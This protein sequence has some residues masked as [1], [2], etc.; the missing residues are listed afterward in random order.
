MNRLHWELEVIERASQ[1]D[2]LSAILPPGRAEQLAEVLTD[3]DVRTL[4]HL[5]EKG[6]GENSLRALTSDFGYIEAWARAATGSPLPWPAP[7][8]LVLKFV[9]HHLWD[10][11][12]RENDPS[13][14]MPEEVRE[15]L[16]DQ[17][18]LRSDGPHAVSTVR[19]RLSSWA[20]LSSWRGLAGEFGAPQLRKALRLASRAQDRRRRSKSARALS[21]D[22]L[23]E[24]L[25]ALDLVCAGRSATG[26][27][28][29]R[30][31]R[32][33]ALRDRAMLSVAF[34]AGGRRRSEIASMSMGQIEMFDRNGSSA[35]LKCRLHLSRTKTTDASDGLSV[36]IVGRSVRDLQAWLDAAGITTGPIFRRVDRWGRIGTR[37]ITAQSVNIAVKR[38]A[39]AVNLDPDDF[40]AH[41]LRSGYMT[42]ALH[43]GLSL[44]EAM[45]Q[46][47]HRSVQQAASYFRA[48]ERS[49]HRAA[50]LLR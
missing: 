49:T 34:S 38:R 2:A 17:G 42:E 35:E 25:D 1:L 44:P 7:L 37:A 43:Q 16:I 24:L 30:A 31:E 9:A 26:L 15:S 22:I 12:E 29:G 10:P 6:M 18:Y 48:D 3:D 36:M 8:D 5:A 39:A 32:L 4:R 41:G 13:H 33:S 27:R 20:T 14:G 23:G 40:S 45:S 50:R 19:R 46:S 21:A 11:L 28:V 47:G